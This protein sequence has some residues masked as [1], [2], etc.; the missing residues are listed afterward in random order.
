MDAHRALQ[1]LRSAG[2]TADIRDADHLVVDGRVVLHREVRS[3]ATRWDAERYLATGE[4]VLLTPDILTPSLLSLALNDERLILVT[5]DEIVIDRE[6][7][8]FLRG[9]SPDRSRRKRGPKPYARFAV[10]RSLLASRQSFT[11]TQLAENAGISQGAVTKA[12][13]ADL[14]H[15]VLTRGH[16]STSV[17]EDGRG[18]LFD[19]I[20]KD[21]PSPGGITTYWWKDAPPLAQAKE[22]HAAHPDT[23]WSGDVLADRISNWRRPEHAVVYSRAGIDPRRLGYAMAQPDNYTLMLVLP[24]DP[25]IEATARTW[26]RPH[27]VDPIIAAYDVLRTG[28]TGDEQESVEKLRDYVIRGMDG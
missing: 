9:D 5:E 26:L 3:S 22:I 19:R 20:L 10:A 2:H 14:F 21:Y 15:D 1:A 13:A 8:F 25:T 11:Q 7:L 24:E 17:A 6:Q 28:T 18:E 27:A 4:D 16:G 12:F 23:R